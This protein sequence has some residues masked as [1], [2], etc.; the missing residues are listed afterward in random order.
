LKKSI[1]HLPFL[2]WDKNPFAVQ[3]DLGK[4]EERQRLRP[5]GATRRHDRDF[6]QARGYAAHRGMNTVSRLA[7]RLENNQVVLYCK[8]I[9][10]F[11]SIV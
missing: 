9:F 4:I 2:N 5:W 10:S 11:L 8:G 6:S 3:N 7:N 1:F